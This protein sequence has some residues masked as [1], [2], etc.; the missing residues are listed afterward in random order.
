MSGDGSWPL[1]KAVYAA[2]SDDAGLKALIGD[3][4]RLYDDVPQDTLFP[5][6][7]LGEVTTAD[8]GT[9]TEKGTAHRLTLHAWSRYGGRKDVKDIMAAVYDALHEADLTL[10]GHH[11][12]SLRFQ[13]SDVFRDADLETYHGV[14]R[15]RALTEPLA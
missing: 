15:Y 10:E 8:W 5:Y 9:A 14:M 1:Q 3:P 7:T 4:P 2:L 13:F 6:V 11:L 12:I